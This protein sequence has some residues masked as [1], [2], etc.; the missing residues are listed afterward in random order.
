MTSLRKWWWAGFAFAYP[1]L[2][3]PWSTSRATPYVVHIW[4]T[5]LAVVG[6]VAFGWAADR[7][8]T[9]S[10]HVRR[11]ATVLLRPPLMV[12]LGFV[13]WVCVL[14]HRLTRTRHRAHRLPDRAEQRGVRVPATVRRLRHG[15]CAGAGGPR[16]GK[17]NRGRGG[18]VWRS[19]RCCRARRGAHATP[20]PLP[21]NLRLRSSDGDVPTTGS[22]G[23]HA[24]PLY[25]SRDRQ[26]ADVAR[27]SDRHRNWPY[28][29][30]LRGPSPASAVV[31][32]SAGA[33]V[34]RHRHNARRDDWSRDRYWAR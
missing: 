11:V 1:L 30:S 34:A 24:G 13:L 21:G 31:L 19:T 32:H 4:F 10:G 20:R 27:S 6:G 17:T 12:A 26:W 22:L 14:R 5:V 33:A 25:G 2:W 23:R 3:A 29:E 9:L 16:R 28:L 8:V 18:G 15:L 7:E